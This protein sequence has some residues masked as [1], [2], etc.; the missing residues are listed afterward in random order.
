LTPGFGG[1]D[2]LTESLA[3]AGLVGA[4]FVGAGL[5]AFDL[6]VT[7]FAVGITFSPEGFRR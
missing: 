3:A 1:V 2:F 4:S 5:A 7:G 6:D